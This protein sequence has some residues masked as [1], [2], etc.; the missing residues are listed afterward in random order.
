M[1]VDLALKRLGAQDEGQAVGGSG[2]EEV[3]DVPPHRYGWHEVALSPE[4]EPLADG[5]DGMA[6]FATGDTGY[7]GESF[8]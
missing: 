5:N 1:D 8:A 3:D 4:D 2:E 6:T 7:L